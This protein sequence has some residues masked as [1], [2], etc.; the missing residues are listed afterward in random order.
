LIVIVDVYTLLSETWIL[1]VVVYSIYHYSV[2]GNSLNSHDGEKFST[3]DQDN[4]VGYENCAANHHGA[5]WYW[6][7][8]TS[9][10]NGRYKQAGSDAP[11]WENNYWNAWKNGEALKA[12]VM[13]VRPKE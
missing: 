10:L 3:Y 2:V 8:A 11:S 12:S 4:D 7:C 1:S 13:M 5:W 6:E 9:N